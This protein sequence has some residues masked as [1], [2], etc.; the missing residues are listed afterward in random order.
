MTVIDGTFDPDNKEQIL[1]ALVAGAETAF[2]ESLDPDEAS[3]IR[4]F[5]EAIAEYLATQQEDIAS[6][7]AAS[8]IDNAEGDAL[9]LLASLIGVAP[10]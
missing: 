4:G 3:V 1:D 7:L 5:Y 9:D 2:E 10:L 8:Q 6:V